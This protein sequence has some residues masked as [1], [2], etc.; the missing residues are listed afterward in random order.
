[1]KKVP[2]VPERD[3]DYIGEQVE[4]ITGL[5][6]SRA[7]DSRPVFYL[8]ANVFWRGKDDGRTIP[9]A[10]SPPAAKYLADHLNQAIEDY[11]AGYPH[12]ETE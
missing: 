11:L 5:A 7:K 10:L 1:M 3:I 2:K 9:F 12:P 8:E 4:Q 6:V